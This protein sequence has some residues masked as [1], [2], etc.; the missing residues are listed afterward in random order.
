MTQEDDAINFRMGEWFVAKVLAGEM[1]HD[2]GACLWEVVR[3]ALCACMGMNEWSPEK[4]QVKVALV[5]GHPLASGSTM[6]EVMDA[7]SGFTSEHLTRYSTIGPDDPGTSMRHGGAA[8]KQIGRMATFALNTR[9][10]DQEDVQDGFFILTRT[11]KT[12]GVRKYFLPAA[13]Q[14]G[15]SLHPEI[16]P[17]DSLELGTY[18][19]YAGSF[20]V[21]L[22]PHSAFKSE[23]EI[24]EALCWCMP[25]KADRAV[26]VYVGG[27]LLH[28]PPLE[29]K[30]IRCDGGIEAHL[31]H[32]RE[33]EEGGIW[34]CDARTALRCA[35]APSLGL[36]I[37]YPLAR[38]DLI[39]DIFIPGLL[40]G[41]V[42][43]RS[44][45]SQDHLKSEAWKKAH[46]TLCFRVAPFAQSILGDEDVFHDR[47][48]HTQLVRQIADLFTKCWGHP[49]ISGGPHGGGGDGGDK[50][51]PRPP[52]PTGPPDPPDIP[53]RNRGVAVHIG[54]DDF[55]LVK[56]PNLNPIIYAEVTVDGRNIGL[57]PRYEIPLGKSIRGDHCLDKILSAVGMH[58]H[59]YDTKEAVYYAANLRKQLE[60]TRRRK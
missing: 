13:I 7:G 23:Q 34:L 29:D 56:Y 4:T 39:G 41:Q 17:Y 10:R 48:E 6:L 45:L 24:R 59:P 43:N 28:A 46:R 30:V 54:D 16:I 52:K 5:T 58:K 40:G 51:P 20:T 47:D 44:G 25:R 9:V 53:P 15:R 14:T 26:K 18:R 35:Y 50:G 27:K 3:N 38:P 32:A 21:I 49:S 55:F 2:A 31:Q 19:R 36:K 60:Q 1:Y 37:P 8:Q 22:I 12:G 42:T 33:D 57:N 11:T